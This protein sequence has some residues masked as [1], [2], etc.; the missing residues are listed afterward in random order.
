MSFSQFSNLSLKE[1]PGNNFE[2]ATEGK[3]G[4][5]RTRKI[6]GEMNMEEMSELEIKPGKNEKSCSKCLIY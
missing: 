4:R 1:N 6:L 5:L 3:R 2:S